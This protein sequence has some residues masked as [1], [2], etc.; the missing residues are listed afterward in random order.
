MLLPFAGE[1]KSVNRVTV[2]FHMSLFEV[3]CYDTALGMPILLN[4]ARRLVRLL[5]SFRSLLLGS[6]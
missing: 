1:A 6:R 3:G 4:D 2:E 5:L